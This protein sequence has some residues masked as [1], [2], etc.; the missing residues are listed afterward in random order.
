M[1]ES[2]DATDVHRDSAATM[3]GAA[4]PPVSQSQSLPVSR[5][6]ASPAKSAQHRVE[7]ASE[8]RTRDWAAR[9]GKRDGMS[10]LEVAGAELRE[11]DERERRKQV[12]Q[13]LSF[14]DHDRDGG[15]VRLRAGRDGAGQ[16]RG[17]GSPGHSLRALN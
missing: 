9:H 11:A 1:D 16:E 6:E 8:Q 15:G 14:T 2:L 5:K 12:Q 10:E 13:Q 17:I 3:D 4:T 7:T